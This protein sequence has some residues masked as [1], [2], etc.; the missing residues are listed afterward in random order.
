MAVVA[1][2]GDP[3]PRGGHRQPRTRDR[4]WR[5]RPWH[6][7]RCRRH[8]PHAAASQRGGDWTE[9]SGW[10]SNCARQAGG[11][12]GIV[13]HAGLPPWLR[14]WPGEQ[15]A[16]LQELSVSPRRHR[17]VPRW[18]PPT[19]SSHSAAPPTVRPPTGAQMCC[20]PPSRLDAQSPPTPATGQCPHLHTATA[21]ATHQSRTDHPQDCPAREA[22]C[23]RTCG[24]QPIPRWWMVQGIVRGRSGLCWW[25]TLVLRQQPAGPKPRVPQLQEPGGLGVQRSNTLR[26]V[27]RSRIEHSA[28]RRLTAPV[29]SSGSSIIVVQ[30]IH[31]GM[32][33]C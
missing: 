2:G 6:R 18:H 7:R 1:V 27:V 9:G 32:P 23:A 24:L 15:V 3:Q 22:T 21:T 13:V 25:H 33:F 30:G 17:T 28:G 20:L 31:T 4:R 26:H 11:A 8:H 10:D 16:E 5:R 14:L 19:R 12:E 29:G